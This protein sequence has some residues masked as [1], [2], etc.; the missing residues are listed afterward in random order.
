[1][2]IMHTF[3]GSKG[4]SSYGYFAYIE[5]GEL[6]IGEN[7]PREG[8]ETYRG[9]YANAERALR[10]LEK[11]APVLYA[12]IIRYYEEHKEKA[13]SIIVGQLKPGD[14]FI[15]M[16][17]GSRHTFVVINVDAL[18]FFVNDAGRE[19][20]VAYALDLE[21]YRIFCFDKKLEVEIANR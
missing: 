14:K 10:T 19:S 12:N 6:V 21:S 11:E 15:H 17:H 16:R 9:S 8:G 1:M 5:N 20:Y 13:N 4:L 3:K 2:A 18:S 7:W